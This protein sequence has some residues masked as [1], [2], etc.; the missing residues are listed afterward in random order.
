MSGCSNAAVL[1]AASSEIGTALWSPPALDRRRFGGGAA[2][3]PSSLLPASRRL[4]ALPEQPKRCVLVLWDA[5]LALSAAHVAPSMLPAPVLMCELP[6][7]ASP[8]GEAAPLGVLAALRPPPAPMLSGRAVALTTPAM[9]R[10][11]PLLAGLS[12][13]GRKL[14]A[15]AP[16]PEKLPPL[17]RSELPSLIILRRGLA[18]LLALLPRRLGGDAATDGIVTGSWKQNPPP[19]VLL[20]LLPRRLAGG[21]GDA[22]TSN[23]SVTGSW[24]DVSL[25]RMLLALL[26]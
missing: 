5:V 18:L 8:G 16:L 6:P 1:K 9:L 21:G 10:Q 25:P 12:S 19:P 17:P 26:P 4:A 7:A 15:L 24:K 2:A 11:L 22:A 13:T 3:E 23:G 14:A 20:A